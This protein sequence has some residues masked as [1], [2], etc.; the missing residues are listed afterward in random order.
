[1][2]KARAD[3]RVRKRADAVRVVETEVRS[4]YIKEW[5]PFLLVVLECRLEIVKLVHRLGNVVLLVV[6]AGDLFRVLVQ[7]LA[8]YRV[9]FDVCWF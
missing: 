1:M 6:D 9:G 3:R 7:N 5:P 8:R 2:A 4:V